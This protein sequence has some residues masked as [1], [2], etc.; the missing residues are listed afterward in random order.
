MVVTALVCFAVKVSFEPHSC[1][2]SQALLCFGPCVS[3]P[4][5]AEVAASA[6]R[7]EGL[8]QAASSVPPARLP[9]LMDMRCYRASELFG[10]ANAHSAWCSCSGDV[11]KL[12]KECACNISPYVIR[13]HSQEYLNCNLGSTSGRAAGSMLNG[14]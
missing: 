2:H 9:A 5:D 11:K 4:V 1:E 10:V 7:E 14:F 13:C 6:G 8:G 12:Q 3:H